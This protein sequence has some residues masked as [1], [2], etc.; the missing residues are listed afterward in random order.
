MARL[1]YIVVEGPIG[2]GKTTLARRLAAR[3]SADVLLE[4]PQENPFL[5]RFYQDMPRFALPTQLFFL[6]QRVQM[7]EPL[8]QPDLFGALRNDAEGRVGH[9]VPQLEGRCGAAQPHSRATVERVCV[10]DLPPGAGDAV[11]PRTPQSA[12]VAASHRQQGSA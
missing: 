12:Q 10:Y 3:L 9:A 2:A 5:G 11:A 7:L 4:Q 6:F 8:A 1:R